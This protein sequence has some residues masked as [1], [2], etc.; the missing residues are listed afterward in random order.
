MALIISGL[1]I[2]VSLPIEIMSAMHFKPNRANTVAYSMGYLHIVFTLI[3]IWL[4]QILT[5][6]NRDKIINHFNRAIYINQF[7]KS[8]CKVEHLVDDQLARKIKLRIWLFILQSVAILT[9][10][11]AYISRSFFRHQASSF[12]RTF[13]CFSYINAIFVTTIYLGGSLMLCDRYC[14]LLCLQVRE[15]RRKI[16]NNVVRM[17]YLDYLKWKDNL[18]QTLKAYDVIVMFTENSHNLFASHAV[19]CAVS[20]FIISLH[21]VSVVSFS[22]GK[23]FVKAP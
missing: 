22:T 5:I 11:N 17:D 4:N 23:I 2:V 20:T 6:I 8:V 1:I 10:V 3:K 21:G 7:L 18:N 19:V 9:G 12:V 14:R 13:I 15:L 16:T